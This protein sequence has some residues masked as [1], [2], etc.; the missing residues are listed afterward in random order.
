M[1]LFHLMLNTEDTTNGFNIPTQY[2]LSTYSSKELAIDAILGYKQDFLSLIKMKIQTL[3][4][5]EELTQKAQKEGYGRIP[6]TW[7]ANLNHEL[8]LIR[9]ELDDLI[10][11]ILPL[12]KKAVS[13]ILDEHDEF[14]YSFE[15][16]ES[17]LK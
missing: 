3:E 6:Y 8:D 4:K 17:T 1:Q 10:I 12:A 7:S 5:Q 13:A 2:L 15:V 11:Q 9:Q 16:I 14:S